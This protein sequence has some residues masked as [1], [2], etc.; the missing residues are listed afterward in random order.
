M[1]ESGNSIT[2]V[3]N[4]LL[5]NSP[6]SLVA[7]GVYIVAS[8]AAGRTPWP[9]LKIAVPLWQISFAGIGAAIALFGGVLLWHTRT[10]IDEVDPSKYQFEI[11]SPKPYASVPE[12]L[13]NVEGDLCI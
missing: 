3:V 4:K 5:E 11:V 6:L 13:L 9:D 8:A 12:R 7:L 1:S 10:R 2:T